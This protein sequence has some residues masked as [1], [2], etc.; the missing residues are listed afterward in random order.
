MVITTRDIKP[1][2]PVKQ[3]SACLWAHGPSGELDE[4]GLCPICAQE[5]EDLD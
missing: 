3:E 4:R 2:E 5:E 1:K